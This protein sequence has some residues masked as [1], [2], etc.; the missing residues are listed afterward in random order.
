V[1][2]GVIILTITLMTE[3]ETVSV[4]LGDNSVLTDD[5]TGI[6]YCVQSQ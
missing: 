4:A 6:H 3:A 2:S 1:I 5:V